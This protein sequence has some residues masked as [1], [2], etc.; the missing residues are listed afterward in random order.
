M[1]MVSYLANE[2]WS[3]APKCACPVLTRY[4]ININDLFTDEDRQFLKPLI[5]LLINTVEDDKIRI[6]RKQFMMFRNVT[7]TYPLIMDLVKLPEI[8]SK[9]RTFTNCAA[10]MKE[11]AN[12]LKEHRE[13]IYAD[14]DANA[15]ANAYANAYAYAYADANAYAY[16]DADANAY[17]YAD[18]YAN[19]YANANA[20]AS[21]RKKIAETA[22][23]T[24]RLAIEIKSRA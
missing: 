19:A 18:A 2:P 14:A 24:L 22:V 16:A 21:L 20:N 23:E 6:L 9:L 11:A 13:T 5:P 15:N 7:V 4:A 10:D 17:A 3:D 1:E 8:A 12:F